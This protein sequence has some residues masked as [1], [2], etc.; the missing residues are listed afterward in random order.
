VDCVFV[1]PKGKTEICHSFQHLDIQADTN[2]IA[3]HSLINKAWTDVL[4]LQI[5]GEGEGVCR[6]PFFCQL[7]LEI[8]EILTEFLCLR[9]FCSFPGV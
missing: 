8:R 7:L 2:P 5:A 3:F 9:H 4:D 6:L 1:W